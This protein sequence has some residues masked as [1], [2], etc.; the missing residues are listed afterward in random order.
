MGIISRL[1]RSRDEEDSHKIIASSKHEE[2]V[3]TCQ[4]CGTTGVEGEG[5]HYVDV[6]F[7]IPGFPKHVSVARGVCYETHD[8][9]SDYAS[10]CCGMMYESGELYCASC[11]EPL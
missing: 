6:A 3:E 11:G 8:L 1:F 7:Q 10:Y 4:L 5:I 9:R 2:E